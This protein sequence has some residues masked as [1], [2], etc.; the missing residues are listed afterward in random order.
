[1]PT[2]FVRLML[3]ISS[4]FPLAIIFWILFIMQQPV[5]AWIV[6]IIG[7]LGLLCTFVYFFKISARMAPIQE[8][9]S[10][11]QEKGSDVMGYI[12]SYVVPFAT[13][14]LS[15][16]QQMAAL[17]VFMIVLS[18]VYINSEMIR[19]NPLLSLMGYHLY[20]ITVEHGEDSVSLITR[21]H[22]KRGDTIRIVDV[23]RGIFLE[24]TV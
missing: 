20:E 24:K 9:I 5:L 22:V 1:M 3:F 8:K 17:L 13:F 14:P 12:A 2:I 23:G 6:V 15:G 16:W 11:R 4:Y 19:V 21:N 7:G 18:I 10:E